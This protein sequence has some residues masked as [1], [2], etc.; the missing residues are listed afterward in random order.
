MGWTDSHLHE[1]RAGDTRYSTPYSEEDSSGDFIDAR[2][3]RLRHA[4]KGIGT[5]TLRYLYDFGDGWVYTIKVERLVDAEPGVVYP[6]L[7]AVRG[8]CPPEDCGGP[9]GYARFR[10]AIKDPSHNRHVEL[11]E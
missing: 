11:T 5:K 6:Q 9:Y 3:A 7:I 8:R 2:T 4:L 10:A 1:I